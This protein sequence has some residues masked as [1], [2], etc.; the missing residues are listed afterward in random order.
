MSRTRIIEDNVTA[1]SGSV[2]GAQRLSRGHTQNTND[3]MRQSWRQLSDGPFRSCGD[4]EEY[5]RH[6]LGLPGTIY[7]SPTRGLPRPY[8]PCFSYLFLDFNGKHLQAT[9]SAG[10]IFILVSGF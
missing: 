10:G 2:A 1:T 3:D 8:N 6:P 4:E 9:F 5:I 7:H